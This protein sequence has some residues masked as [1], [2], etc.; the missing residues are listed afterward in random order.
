MELIAK[1]EERLKNSS[2][3]IDNY[4]M[5]YLVNRLYN[6]LQFNVYF[7][8]EDLKF[9]C[10]SFVIPW[11]KLYLNNFDN[12]EIVNFKIEELIISELYS[13]EQIWNYLEKAAEFDK[14][15]KDGL[16]QIGYVEQPINYR[17]MYSCKG[18]NLGAIFIES[19]DDGLHL[20]IS[21][22]ICLLLSQGQ[23][24]IHEGNIERF[25]GQIEYAERRYFQDYWTMN[26]NHPT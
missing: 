4:L 17:L 12:T 1:I 7:P 13:S 25:G 11:D 5:F 23:I 9:K 3:Q 6:S 24:R 15:F 16:I 8:A 2:F 21:S 19:P 14:G 22:N 18:D 26:S 20:K 10:S